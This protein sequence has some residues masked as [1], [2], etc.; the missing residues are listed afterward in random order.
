[1]GLLIEQYV[2]PQELHDRMATVVSGL[3]E[4]ELKDAQEIRAEVIRKYSNVIPE[5]SIFAEDDMARGFV[6]ATLASIE[7]VLRAKVQKGDT[8]GTATEQA[9]HATG[10]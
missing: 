10:A 5:D 2:T 9:G 8:N 3:S 1:M 7:R 4:S 6:L